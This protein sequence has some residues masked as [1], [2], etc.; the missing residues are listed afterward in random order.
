MLVDINDLQRKYKFERDIN[1]NKIKLIPLTQHS[2]QCQ[3]LNK[4]NIL[5]VTDEEFI[6]LVSLKKQFDEDLTKV[7]DY[8]ITIQD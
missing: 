2:F 7:I 3:P 6:G 1:T 5:E 4:P 8:N